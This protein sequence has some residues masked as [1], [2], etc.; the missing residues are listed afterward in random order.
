MVP[1]AWVDE[2]L[3][4]LN[5]AILHGA[6]PPALLLEQV[7]QTLLPPL[8][9]AHQLSRDQAKRLVVRLGFVGASVARHHQ[10]H[11]PAGKAEPERAFDGLSADGMPF[12]E[13]F[14]ALA[15]RTGEG[16]YDR[17]SFASLVRWNVGTLE[18]RRGEELMAVLPGAFDDGRIRSYTGTRGE[19]NFFLLVKRGEAIELAINDVLEPL[20]E[21]PLLD[22]DAVDRLRAATELVE[23]LRRLLV[24]FA[25]APPEES[26]P[27][28]Q[29]LDVFRQFAVHWTTG[30]IPPSGAL[31]PEALKRDFLLGIDLAGYDHHVRRLFPALLDAERD[32]LEALMARPTL[33]G[34][35]LDELRLDPDELRCA[36]AAELRRLVGRQPAVADWYRLLAAHARAAGAHLMLSK[37]YLFKPQRKR[38]E[39]GLGDRPLVSNRA[40]TTGMN[41]MFLETLTR[42]RKQ[43]PLAPLR[44]ALTAETGEKSPTTGVRSGRS[45]SVALVG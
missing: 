20:A 24:D 10:E 17:D 43:H 32:E 33:P 30:D 23:A 13:Y 41:E 14:A 40:G 27:A 18:V 37:K 38:D 26:M 6:A 39:A 1:G 21:A 12:R 34:R 42:A 36:P 28:E 31:D 3:P 15:A 44:A 16:H 25:A 35:L 4:R 22:D 11:D 45:V 5:S 8:P 7:A 19:E 9:P 29:F 2:E